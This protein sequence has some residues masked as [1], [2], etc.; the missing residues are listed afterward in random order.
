MFFTTIERRPT[1]HSQRDVTAATGD[2]PEA[3]M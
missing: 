2:C 1:I 3:A